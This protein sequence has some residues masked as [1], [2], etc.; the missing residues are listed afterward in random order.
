MPT[1]I[2]LAVYGSAAFLALL[3]LYLFRARAWYWHVLSVLVALAIGLTPIPA[4]LRSPS[5][6]LAVGSVVLF[7]VLW[8][9]CAPAFGHHRKPRHGEPKHA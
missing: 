6:D 4:A 2:I 8:G 1:A 5:T 9:I 3:L 7:L